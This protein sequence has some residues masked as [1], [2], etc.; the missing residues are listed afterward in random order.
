V[1]VGDWDLDGAGADEEVEEGEEE[2][3]E[4]DEEGEECVGH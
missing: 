1:A 4:E 2:E 3:R